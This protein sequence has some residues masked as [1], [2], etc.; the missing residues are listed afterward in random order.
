VDPL[1]RRADELDSLQE[2]YRPRA[3]QAAD[4][5]ELLLG[6]KAYTKGLALCSRSEVV[7]RLPPGRY[8]SLRALAGID[9]RVRPD[10]NVTL[11]IFG[12]DKTLYEATLTG[13]D[14]PQAVD[15]DLSG[16]SRLKILVDFGGGQEVS[17]HLDLCDPRML[18]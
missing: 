17:D 6:K 8:R 11:T 16:V 3:N 4:G 18:K 14:D 15:V 1:F 12:N 2:F 5:D 13:H 9:D 10:G 7:Y